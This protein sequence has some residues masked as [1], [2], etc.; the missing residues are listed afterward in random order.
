MRSAVGTELPRRGFRRFCSSEPFKGAWTLPFRQEPWALP[1]AVSQQ[2]ALDAFEHRRQPDGPR[3]TLHALRP[4]QLPF[5]VFEGRLHVKFT[6][7]VGYD[8]GGSSDAHGRVQASEFTR[9]NLKCPPLELGADTGSVMAVYAG[10]NFRR[11]FV[12]QALAGDIS[13]ALLQTAVPL[14]FLRDQPAGTRAA[15]FEMKPSFAYQARL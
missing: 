1:F 15:D 7:V 14:T 11:L 13:N 8:D 6:G 10:F 12:R 9:R 5:Y 3:L 4:F 2:A